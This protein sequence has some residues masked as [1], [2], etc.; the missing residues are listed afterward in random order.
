MR[1]SGLNVIPGVPKRKKAPARSEQPRK[2][3]IWQASRFNQ[4]VEAII[5]A[6]FRDIHDEKTNLSRID[7]VY[8]GCSCD[9]KKQDL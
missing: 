4:T 3:Q 1:V 9:W 8:F 7:G 2:W 5:G 6:L